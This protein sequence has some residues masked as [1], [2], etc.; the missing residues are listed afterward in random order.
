MLTTFFP[1]VSESLSISKRDVKDDLLTEI[2]EL[3]GL[4][5]KTLG[6]LKAGTVRDTLE[7]ES[8]EVAEKALDALV[9]QIKRVDPNSDFGKL[10]LTAL[11]ALLKQAVDALKKEI[12]KA[13]SFYED[14]K[15]DLKKSIDQL[16]EEAK[17]EIE[18][19]KAEGKGALTVGIESVEKKLEDFESQLEKLN[20]TTEV[21]KALL[22]ALEGLVK[23]EEEQLKKEIAKVSGSFYDDTKDDLK[24]SIDQLKEEAKKEIEKL[25]A[26]GKGALAAGI[27]SAEKKLED[28][29]SQLEKLNPTTDVGKALLTVLEGLV[30]KAEEE[31]KAEIA[32][33]SGSFYDDTKDDLKK[34]IDQLKEEAKKEIEK[35]E[36]EGKGAL[37]SGIQ[38]VEKKLEDFES[39]LEKL[40]PTTEVGK[41]LL[42]ALEGLV[43][44][45]E[46]Q[47][48]KEIAKVSGSYYDTKDDLKNSIDQLKEE[49]KKEIEKL[50]AEG[51][52]ALASGIQ[53]AEKK[54][55]D[56][57]SQ[58]EKLNPTTD[59][60]KA[61]LSALEGL[62]KKAEEELKAEIAKVS[63]SYYEG[64]LK[65]QLLIDAAKL[66]KEA[67]EE[68]EKLK[69]EGKGELAKG[70]EAVEKVVLDLE[71]QLQALNSSSEVGKAL[72]STLEALL[73]KAETKL[74][75]EI[76]K[77]S[78][79]YYEEDVKQTLIDEVNKLKKEAQ[80]EIEKLKKE[81]KGELAKGIEAVE[82][83]VVD[84]ETQLEKLNPSTD[85]GKALLATLENVLK[86]EAAALDAELKKLSGSFYEEN[87]KDDLKDSINKLKEEAKKE[88]EKLENEGKGALAV[89]I[90]TIEKKLEDFESQVEKLNPTTEIGKALLSAVE[91]LVKKAEEELKAEIAKLSGSFYG[92]SDDLKKELADETEKLK[93]E[94]EAEIEKLKK[95][96]KTELSKG[97]VEIE[98]RLVDIETQLEKVDTTNELGK[99]LLHSLEG[100]L[101]KAETALE[102]EIKKLSGSFYSAG[103]DLK[104]TLADETEK[105]RKEA[106]AEIEKLIN[107]GKGELAKGIQEVEKR[108]VDI[109]TQLEKL[110]PSNE[111]GK[112]LL[113]TLEGLLKKAETALEDELKKLSGS[114]YGASDDLK[115]ELADETEKLK[116]EAEA[117]IEKLKKE[118]KTE[119]SKGLVEIEKRLVD[120]ETQLEKVNTTNEVGKALL[121]SLEGLLKKAETAL[122]AEIKK[123]SGSF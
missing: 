98:K 84:I 36:A 73:K 105:L 8:I 94:A 104:K 86:K 85:V 49:A 5:D 50:E 119:L 87:T 89:G 40:N 112:A 103:D 56:F 2:N 62:V 76:K 64:D 92:A 44:R 24:K 6:K 12:D 88:I 96:G 115:K 29:E 67:E 81:G 9:S 70:L 58:L 79:S 7:I 37:A 117:E 102:D 78:G 52:G 99:A 118:G 60:G 107:E 41:A 13:G 4:A 75:E 97:L 71:S 32:K 21:G 90:Q 19:L 31:L 51:K 65:D 114:F 43:K 42:T 80:D 10:E 20:P 34:S 33:V 25:E 77:L 28:F 63:G 66:K 57:E 74:E 116:K 106:E 54:L 113:N 95:E 111:I 17:K 69:K 72:L 82:K 27:Q 1:S 91:G 108:I 110:N 38:S 100:L 35:L 120:I 16:K 39:Q 30:K 11:D 123:L 93:K 18:K 121:N 122:E 83:R 22:T 55:E 46:E 14:T 47:L 59:V 3:K 45:E 61:L 68:I 15:D 23:K 26:E 109:E 48:K 101:K 53:S